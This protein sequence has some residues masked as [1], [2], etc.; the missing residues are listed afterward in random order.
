MQVAVAK[1]DRPKLNQRK[2]SELEVVQL[3][4]QALHQELEQQEG[5]CPFPWI[6][7]SYLICRPDR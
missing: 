6:L 7:L 3:W 2:G 1:L 5:L 4:G